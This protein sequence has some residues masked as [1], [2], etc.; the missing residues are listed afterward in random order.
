MGK[1]AEGG[2]GAQGAPS[3]LYI[4]KSQRGDGK[5]GE[6][7]LGE[8]WGLIRSEQE[9]DT[10]A[11]RGQTQFC[12]RGTERGSGKRSRVLRAVGPSG[13]MCQQRTK[14]DPWALPEVKVCSPAPAQD[15]HWDPLQIQSHWHQDPA[16]HRLH[17]PE[18][19]N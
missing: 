10:V 7:D 16:W 2:K 1:S 18:S 17:Q 8:A 13:A 19:E 5:A 15:Q 6:K 4:W 9:P 12:S 11:L 3:G 14:E